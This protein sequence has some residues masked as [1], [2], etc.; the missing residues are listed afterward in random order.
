[1]VEQ[2]ARSNGIDFAN[3]AK[4]FWYHHHNGLADGTVKGF[5]SIFK[6]AEKEYNLINSGSYGTILHPPAM[7]HLPKNLANNDIRQK[8]PPAPPPKKFSLQSKYQST[9]VSIIII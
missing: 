5:I 9:S 4:P 3:E 6:L 7:H 8:W 1:M 2:F